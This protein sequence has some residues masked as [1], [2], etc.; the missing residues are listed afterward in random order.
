MICKMKILHMWLASN[1]VLFVYIFYAISTAKEYHYLRNVTG[2]GLS[3][4]RASAAIILFNSSLLLL[5][6]CR[7][8]ISALKGNLLI[9]IFL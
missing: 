1:A 6:V 8:T 5:F 2:I 4:S 9:Q 3:F 7:N